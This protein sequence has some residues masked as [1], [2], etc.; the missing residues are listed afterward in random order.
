MNFFLPLGGW[1]EWGEEEKYML[2]SICDN[3]QDEI[4]FTIYSTDKREWII[5]TDFHIIDRYYPKRL[6]NIYSVKEYENYFDV[7]NK[8]YTFV[9]SENCPEEFVYIYDDVLLVKKIM[10]DGIFNIPQCKYTASMFGVFQKSRYGRTIN[11]AFV[12]SG[13]KWNFEHHCPLIYKRDKLRE[14][15]N[16]YPFQEM[17]IPYS[18]ATLYFNLYKEEAIFEPLLENY[19]A[20]FEG[21]TGRIA[22]HKQDT[23]HDIEKAVKDKTWVSFNDFGISWFTPNYDGYPLRDWIKN[24]FSNKSKFEA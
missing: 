18:L 21:F 23:L 24:N 12:L 6:L 19:K 1:T 20:G 11:Q 4:S 3:F 17:N 10:A 9:N 22:T 16:K 15:F 13:S 8:V 5:N 2:R 14:M 7:L